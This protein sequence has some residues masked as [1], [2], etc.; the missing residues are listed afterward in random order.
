MYNHVIFLLDV[1]RGEILATI[2]RNFELN[3]E[4][5]KAQVTVDEIDFFAE[6]WKSNLDSQI[7]NVQVILVADV[8]YDPGEYQNKPGLVCTVCKED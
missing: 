2:R 3:S 4:L 1:D 6:D 8:V 5:A 7:Q